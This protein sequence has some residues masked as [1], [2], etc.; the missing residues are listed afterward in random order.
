LPYEVQIPK[1][2]SIQHTDGSLHSV[3]SF[4][5]RPQLLSTFRWTST[6][7]RS[8]NLFRPAGRV[9]GLL[10]PSGLFR[11]RNMISRKL[12]GFTSLKATCVL[13]LQINAQ[14]FQCGRLLMAAAPMPGLW[15]IEGSLYFHMFQMLKI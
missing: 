10:V 11:N 9:E 7:A 14:P 13:K 2:P 1:F 8:E 15:V 4:L 5:Q 6:A 3:V 12:D